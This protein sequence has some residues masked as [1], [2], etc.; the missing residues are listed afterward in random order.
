MNNRIL[1]TGD[2]KINDAIGWCQK[3][4]HPDEWKL[5]F[6]GWGTN[7]GKYAITFIDDKNLIFANL[8][9]SN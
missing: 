7:N 5:D 6:V 2:D 1:I 3:H 8:K 9:F 4:L